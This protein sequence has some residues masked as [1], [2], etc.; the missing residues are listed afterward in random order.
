MMN[1]FVILQTDHTNH[2]TPLSISKVVQPDIWPHIAVCDSDK[3]VS[4]S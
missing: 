4:T 1:V 3:T 2:K